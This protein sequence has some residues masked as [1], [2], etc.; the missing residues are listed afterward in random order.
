MQYKF[1]AIIAL[2]TAA[3]AIPTKSPPVS[4]GDAA[5]PAA[6]LLLR[7]SDADIAV[8]LECSDP[9]HPS[10]CSVSSWPRRLDLAL[11]LTVTLK[12]SSASA[13]LP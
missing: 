10:K 2:A 7:Q 4:G 3:V 9:N 11:C 6:S 12:A 8:G 1:L 13:A 5:D